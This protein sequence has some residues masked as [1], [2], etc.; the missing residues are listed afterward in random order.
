MPNANDVIYAHDLDGALLYVNRAGTEVLGYNQE[1]FSTLRFRDL[2]APKSQERAKRYVDDLLQGISTS[3]GVELRVIS[4]DGG[5]AIVQLR[6]NVLRRG[7]QAHAVH[8]IMRDITAEKELTEQLVRSDRLA[9]V[10]GLIAG[11]AHQL[12]SPLTAISGYVSLLRDELSGTGQAPTIAALTEQ[13][14][15]CLDIARN[16]LDFARHREDRLGKVDLNLLTQ[17]VLDLRGHD[18]TGA[19][20]VVQTQFDAD[21]PEVTGDHLQLQQV[22]YNIVDNAYHAMLDQGGG[23]LLVATRSDDGSAVVTVSDTGPG[24][25]TEAATRVFEPFFTTNPGTATGLGL[26]IAR[27]MVEGHGGR[28]SAANE[29]DG[30]TLVT[31]RLPIE[32]AKSVPA[33]QLEAKQ[34]RRPATVGRVLFVDDEPALCSLVTAALSRTGNEVV[35][36]TDGQEGLRLALSERFDV[37]ICDIRLPYLEGDEV[38]RRIIEE[39]PELADRLLVITG[40]VLSAS[41]QSF[42]EQTRLPYLHKPFTL[43]QIE[44]IVRRS[45]AGEPIESLL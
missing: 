3:H 15:R 25:P 10:G 18:L 41:T 16:L 2:L 7:G 5:I 8:G 33:P 28:I 39:R 20:I 45:L 34:P 44:D 29:A 37:I 43:Q 42:L 27:H 32:G 4:R 9:A 6:A 22:L 13:V 31:V 21:L 40:D 24:I 26:S 38:C 1:E 30:G 12:N 14:Q 35:T 36:A 17:Q 19:D 11:I 23:R